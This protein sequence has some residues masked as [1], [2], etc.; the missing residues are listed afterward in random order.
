MANDQFEKPLYGQYSFVKDSDRSSTL[1]NLGVGGAAVA[2]ASGADTTIDVDASLSSLFTTVP[3]GVT[4]AVT[5]LN[6]VDGQVV[7]VIVDNADTIT[8]SFPG[9]TGDIVAQSAGSVHIYEVINAGGSL[10]VK[11]LPVVEGV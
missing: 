4:L 9:A 8:C 2:V 3:T 1:A 11:Q 10:Y 7:R 5:V 6:S